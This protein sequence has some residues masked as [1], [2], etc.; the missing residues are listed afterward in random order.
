MKMKDTWFNF[1]IKNPILN[2]IKDVKAYLL[3]KFTN[4]W[5][6]EKCKKNHSSR[7]I[8]YPYEISWTNLQGQR[9]SRITGYS[10]EIE[11]LT[12]QIEDSPKIKPI[13]GAAPCVL[14]Y[15]NKINSEENKNK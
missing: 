8:Q 6:C 7:V 9:V 15:F 14:E 11:V 10:C 12:K 3:Y 4:Y 13:K 5:Y 1:Y 2:L